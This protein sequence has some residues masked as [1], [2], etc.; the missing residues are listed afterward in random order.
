MG[1][2]IFYVLLMRKKSMIYSLNINNFVIH[3][4]TLKNRDLNKLI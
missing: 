2:G 1:K 3:L 4:H